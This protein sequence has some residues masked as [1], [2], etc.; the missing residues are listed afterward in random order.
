MGPYHS[1]EDVLIEEG[2]S[3]EGARQLEDTKIFREMC[4]A[5]DQRKYYLVNDNLMK[6]LIKVAEPS[7]SQGKLLVGQSGY[8]FY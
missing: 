4:I 5:P 2:D 6:R 1:G 7:K 3:T 8:S